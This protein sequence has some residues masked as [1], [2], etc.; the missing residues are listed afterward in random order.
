MMLSYPLKISTE[1]T[2]GV[3]C[4]ANNSKS[5][6]S[7]NAELIMNLGYGHNFPYRLFVGTM[8]N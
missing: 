5:T 4:V 7:L 3:Q 8:L 6:F 1:T 2:E